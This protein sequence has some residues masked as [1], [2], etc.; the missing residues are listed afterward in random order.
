MKKTIVR[1]KIPS[2]GSRSRTLFGSLRLRRVFLYRIKK[3]Y[4]SAKNSAFGSAAKEE[5]GRVGELEWVDHDITLDRIRDTIPE[6]FDAIADDSE[7]PTHLPPPDM[8]NAP[9]GPDSFADVTATF[10]F[11]NGFNPRVFL[12]MLSTTDLGEVFSYPWFYTDDA[13]GR[14]VELPAENLL[15]KS[16]TLSCAWR[17]ENDVLSP[18]EILSGFA[19]IT[20]W[21]R[22]NFGTVEVVTPI[23]EDTI[24]LQRQKILMLSATPPKTVSVYAYFEESDKL[25]DGYDVW[26]A[27]HSMGFNWGN[28]DEFHWQD[29][30]FPDHYT[31]SANAADE[32]I[33]Y[34][35][36][37][38]I[39][40]GEQN[41]NTVEFKFRPMFVANPETLFMDLF[42]PRAMAFAGIFDCSLSA[43]VNDDIPAD[44]DEIVAAIKFGTENLA[45]LGTH[46]GSSTMRRLA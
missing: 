12:R 27:L 45:K 14:I 39:A 42:M 29:S 37:E 38:F 16:R 4:R 2:E 5:T 18:E 15:E 9:S 23:N 30:N 46:P 26:M 34:A 17:L 13:D 19:A 41:F 32:Q 22:Q 36:P 43:Y 11:K 44:I 6:T 24:A 35:L 21:L 28:M 1:A 3:A 31:I 8:N 33:G 10:L 40:S 7:E 20:D 25:F